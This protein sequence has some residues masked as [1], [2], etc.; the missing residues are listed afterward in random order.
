M[1]LDSTAGVSLV[2][3]GLGA[4]TGLDSLDVPGDG[5]ERPSILGVEGDSP[6]L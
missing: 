4:S 6:G 1:A 2:G 3:Q 5:R